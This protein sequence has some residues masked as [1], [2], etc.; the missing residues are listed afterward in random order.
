[1]GYKRDINTIHCY[2][3]LAL[4]GNNQLFSR[5]VIHKKFSEAIKDCFE[6]YGLD[7]EIKELAGRGGGGGGAQTLMEILK[8]ALETQG[9]IGLALAVWQIFFDM[10]KMFKSMLIRM[11]AQERTR[12]MINLSFETAE[13]WKDK[14]LGY[15]LGTR[16][17]VSKRICDEI[18]QNLKAKFPIIDID[19]S[20]SLFI[21]PRSFSVHYELP[22]ENQNIFNTFRLMRLFKGLI[23]KDN[24]YTNYKFRTIFIKRTDGKLNVVYGARA[25]TPLKNYFLL[26]STRILGDYLS[27]IY[28]RVSNKH[29]KSVTSSLG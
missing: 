12:A 23:I 5:E 13:D 18:C 7:Y 15:T 3:D 22:A 16:L 10:R 6:K 19:Q 8:L 21:N 11:I 26:F 1:M 28:E 27:S 14:S 4:E 25:R 17:I 24:I 20:F 29:E 9:I 2:V